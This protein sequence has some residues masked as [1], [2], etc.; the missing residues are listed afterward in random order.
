MHDVDKLSPHQCHDMMVLCE[1]Q[2][3]MA[4]IDT[5]KPRNMTFGDIVKERLKPHLDS[6]A[7]YEGVVP[8]E[9][10]VEGLRMELEDDEDH[11]ETDK[12][13]VYFLAKAALHLYREENP[14]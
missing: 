8:A 9:N 13:I 10:L 14:R 7:K 4:N 5:H 1:V 11:D 6:F 3:T 2:A 12:A